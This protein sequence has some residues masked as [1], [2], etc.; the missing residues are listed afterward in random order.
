MAIQTIVFA[1]NRLDAMTYCANE[2]GVPFEDVVWVM[3]LQ[4]LGD[5]DTSQADIHFTD[6]FT[7][8]PAYA[9]ALAA[10]PQNTGDPDA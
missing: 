4:L 3:N 8:M 5:A 1:T 2:L 7:E 9:E 6:A 10:F